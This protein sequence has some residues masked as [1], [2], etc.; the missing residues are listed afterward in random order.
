MMC[1]AKTMGLSFTV[2]V[3]R[4]TTVNESVMGRVLKFSQTDGIDSV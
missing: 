2:D 3:V 1:Y 4:I